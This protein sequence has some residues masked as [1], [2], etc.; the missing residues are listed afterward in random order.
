L[1]LVFLAVVGVTAA[2]ATQAVGALLLLGLVSAP[3]A[4]AQRLTARPYAAMGI[5][6][7][8]AVASM[9]AGLAVAYAAPQLPPSFTILAFS[10]GTYLAALVGTKLRP[11]WGAARRAVTLG[12]TT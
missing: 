5:S 9:W 4:A 11:T 7:G 10:T 3:A 1:G 2:E 12:H 8:I 6:V